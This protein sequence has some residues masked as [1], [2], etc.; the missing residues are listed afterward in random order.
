MQLRGTEL[1]VSSHHGDFS[2]DGNPDGLDISSW[3][4]VEKPKLR[5]PRP[6][7]FLLAGADGTWPLFYRIRELHPHVLCDLERSRLKILVLKLRCEE[8]FLLN[9]LVRNRIKKQ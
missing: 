9:N 3:G 2:R 1:V 4:D 7:G 6:R 8:E 5:L